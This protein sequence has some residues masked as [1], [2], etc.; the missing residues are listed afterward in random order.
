M[1]RN[2]IKHLIYL[3]DL[4]QAERDARLEDLIWLYPETDPHDNLATPTEPL[5]TA[6]EHTGP[7]PS[8]MFP[9]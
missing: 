5:L 4:R 3:A 9:A 7:I 6:E 8:V 2:E 1:N